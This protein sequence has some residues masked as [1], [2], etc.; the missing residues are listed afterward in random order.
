MKKKMNVVKWLVWGIGV[1]VFLGGCK[2]D[3]QDDPNLTADE[4]SWMPY[5]GGET[6]IFKS[7]LGVYDTL[8][9]GQKSMWMQSIIDDESEDNISCKY[10][11][12]ALGIVIGQFNY[13]IWHKNMDITYPKYHGNGPGIPWIDDKLLVGTPANNVVL[14]GKAFN[15]VYNTG[16]IYYTKQQGIVGFIKDGIHDSLFIKI[17]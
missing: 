2:Q 3:C 1:C 5:N 8:K 15:N 10:T 4:L 11:I 12:Q 17:N 9:V 14:N 13:C 16:S 6:L 7:T